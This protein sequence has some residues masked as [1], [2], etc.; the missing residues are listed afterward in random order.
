MR[1][2]PAAARI[3]EHYPGAPEHPGQGC[4]CP[5]R[6]DAVTITNLVWELRAR[7]GHTGT[8][9]SDAARVRKSVRVTGTVQGVGFRPFVY[10]LAARLGLAGF[11]G[12]DSDGRVRRDRRVD[13]AA[14]EEFLVAAWNVTP[15]RWRGSTRSYPQA[16][17]PYGAAG[18]TIAA[19]RHRAPSAPPWCRPTAPCAPTACAE[20]ARSRPTGGTGTRSS[21]APTAGRGS[22]S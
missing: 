14:V 22:P 21:T 3:V 4:C 19:E 7:P 1:T 20:L 11:V 5:A 16:C 13:P 18:F 12:N 2:V 8:V 10:S 15:R 17:R 6:V 9:R